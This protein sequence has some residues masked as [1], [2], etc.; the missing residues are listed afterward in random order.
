MKA[1]LE[2]EKRS[3]D[4]AVGKQ[5]FIQFYVILVGYWFATIWRKTPQ[6]RFQYSLISFLTLKNFISLK[7]L[8]SMKLLLSSSPVLW[9]P[10][11][12]F[13]FSYY[14]TWQQYLTQFSIVSI[15]SFLGFWVTTFLLASLVALYQHT[16]LVAPHWSLNVECAMKYLFLVYFFSSYKLPWWFHVVS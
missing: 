16:F 11:S 2:N 13:Q 15:F 5:H 4:K 7:L 1:S 3:F 6:N 10:W 9:N 8:P 12:N 14:L